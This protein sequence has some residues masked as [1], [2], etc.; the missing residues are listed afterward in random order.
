MRDHRF[1]GLLLAWAVLPWPSPTALAGQAPVQITTQ[2]TTTPELGRSY[3]T[4]QVKQGTLLFAFMPPLQCGVATNAAEGP[5]ITRADSRFGM[6]IQ[7]RPV[8]THPSVEQWRG[9]LISSKRDCIIVADSERR[10]DNQNG[11]MF[12]LIYRPADSVKLSQRVL[13]VPTKDT[14]IEVSCTANLGS[15]VE[16][17]R[18]F[19]LLLGTFRIGVDGKIELPKISGKL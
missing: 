3:R 19:E 1:L 7:A 12:E 9:G 8:T 4:I 18:A 14:L 17:W 6:A 5:I 11:H 13:L 15:E 16:A 10:L 2:T